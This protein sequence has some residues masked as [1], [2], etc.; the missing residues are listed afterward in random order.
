MVPGCSS[1][2]FGAFWVSGM[3]KPVDH[4]DD[5]VDSVLRKADD[6]RLLC[7]LGASYTRLSFIR[8]STWSLLDFFGMSD[9]SLHFNQ[10]FEDG[11]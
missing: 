11:F 2:A 3:P 5:R 10:G 8:A 4:H 7:D 1:V 6:R 9:V